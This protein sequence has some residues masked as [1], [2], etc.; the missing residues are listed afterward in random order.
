VG[1]IR[2][3]EVLFLAT[4]SR[5]WRVAREELPPLLRDPI[6]RCR[7]LIVLAGLLVCAYA[8]G[9]L[10]YVLSTPDIGVRCAFT[11]KVDKFFPDFL[12]PKGQDPLLP[13]DDILEVGN[14]EVKDWPQLLRCLLS[15]RHRGEPIEVAD[16]DALKKKEKK[17]WHVRLDG[18]EIIRVQVEQANGG[19]KRWVWCRLG[20]SPLATLMPTVLWCFIKAGLFLVGA[21]VFWKRPGERSARQFFLLCFVSYGAYVGGYHWQ[22]IATQPTLLLVFMVCSVLLPSVSLHFYLL[23][24]R[25]KPF[26]EHR[27][28]TT[29]LILYGPPVSFLVL[30]LGTYLQI[31]V[32][33]LRGPTAQ[34]YE[35]MP[36]HLE[37]MVNWVYGYFGVALLL[38]LSSIVCLLHSFRVA[39]NVV[40]R[41]QVKWILIGS[42]F[43][44]LPLGYSLYLAVLE[45]A[46]FG[47]GD[48]TWPMFIASLLVTLSF[49]ISITRYR[50]MELDQLVSSGAAYFA[51]SVLAVVLYYGLL[52]TG[53][54]LLGSHISSWPSFGQALGVSCTVL[55]L[56]AVL[57][58]ARSR[59]KKALD[60][61]FRR[62]KY[63]LD[64]T[65]Q[66][67][68]EAVSQLVDPPTL[69]RRLLRTTADL[70]GTERGAVY[71]REGEP[72][73]Y[74]VADSL[75]A[76]PSLTELP[77]GCPLVEELQVHGSLGIRPP[78]VNGAGDPPPAW[79]QLRFLGGEVAHA[80]THEGRMLA[81]LLLGPR[82]SGPYTAEDLNVLSAFAQVTVPAL[83]SGEGGR[84]IE[85]LNR[86]L[87]AKVEKIAEQQRRIL[88]LQSQLRTGVRSQESGARS[89]EPEAKREV[90]SL[91]PDSCS[92]TPGIVGSGP[93]VQ[94]LLTLVRKV[95]AAEQAVLLRGESGTGKELLARAVHD[96]SPRAG[97]P[98]V[99][100]HCAALSTSLLES[101]LFGHVKGAF[102]G[103]V[104]DRPG[105]FEL[106]HGG[107]LFLDEI[108]DVS[109]E[110]QTK[111][112]RVLQEMTF[113][114]VGSSEPIEVDVRIIAATHQ[115]L[116]K[117]I[118]L[119]R[120]R[121]DLFYR[122]NVLP[123]VVPPLRERSE[124]IP[125]L[126]QH[127]LRIY[128]QRCGK[129]DVQM[130]DDALTALKAVPWP[131]N[132]RQLENAIARAVVIAEGSVLTLDD[133]A[134]DLF[135][136]PDEVPASSTDSEVLEVAPVGVQGER[137]ERDRREREQLVRAL[138]AT[139]GNK[140]EAARALGL[141]RSTLLSRLKKHGLS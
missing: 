38:Y 44:L 138:A 75:G 63:Q 9:V 72:P 20:R 50:L 113:E 54:L 66:R 40:E 33:S 88:A 36:Q 122:L 80:L 77:P 45:K 31:R 82:P 123:I 32:L 28:G 83:V 129:G 42:V 5:A 52:F 27:P 89:Q 106:A 120:F 84:T 137:A 127:F 12:Y 29:L 78:S 57:N 125:E 73:L 128:G 37:W 64:R 3:L 4:G 95:A 118:R 16:W 76:A 8:F 18:R 25:P 17:L 86:E 110:V 53:V 69:A 107:T 134:A 108:G 79:R 2:R 13:D 81:L 130:D 91:T 100:V 94:Q 21:L 114:R 136:Q 105:R 124:D 96:H 7:L 23:F 92:L 132:I 10:G 85:S 103:A 112:L 133:L 46:K 47:A 99:R 30:I 131:G 6:R 71:L 97:K 62:E 24:P 139:R 111:L 67:M 104:R 59:L 55:M 117:L 39:L 74:R 26:F 14:R 93:R 61:H 98:F 49:T 56:M 87:Q 101:E 1:R 68:S 60:R 115:D 43:A 116:E 35:A 58:L 65:L 102:T 70:L 135:D 48:A 11:T 34:G 19:G 119:G 109:W 22:G 51:I 15:L 126:V 140:A 41:N 90:S 141:A 121:E